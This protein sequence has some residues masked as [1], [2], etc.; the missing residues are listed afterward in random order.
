MIVLDVP[1]T[2]REKL[3]PLKKQSTRMCKNN[4]SK[5][6]CESTIDL[7]TNPECARTYID[8]SSQ[9]IGQARSS[10]RLSVLESVCIMHHRFH[11]SNGV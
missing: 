2:I 8:D 1:T 3:M 6:N 11:I 7:I 5:I 10:F 4:N 9:L